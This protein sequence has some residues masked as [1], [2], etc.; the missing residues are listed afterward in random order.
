VTDP[1]LAARYGRRNSGRRPALLAGGLTAAAGL[2]WLGWVAVEH[3]NPPVASRLLGFQIRS[4]VVATATIQVDRRDDVA[5]QCQ[6][7]AKA[8]DFS[9]VGETTVEVPAEAPR[10]HVVTVPISTQRAATSVALIGC[11]TEGSERPR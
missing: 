3:A 11:T 9:I 8:S 1:R 2:A 5:A 4:A 7:Q 10:R 6:L